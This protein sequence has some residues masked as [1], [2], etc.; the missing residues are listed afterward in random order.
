MERL[1]HD[2]WKD[3]AVSDPTPPST[4]RVLG[5]VAMSDLLV[6]LVLSIVGL[7]QDRQ[8]FSIAGV[9]LL[10]SGGGMLTW[11]ALRRNQPER[12]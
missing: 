6:G 3:D 1:Y 8:V 5:L 2:W 12:L 4:T 10:I 7:S 9:V 11:V